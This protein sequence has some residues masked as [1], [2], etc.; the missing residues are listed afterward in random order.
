MD[1]PN[2]GWLIVLIAVFLVVFLGSGL[3][4]GMMGWGA[5]GRG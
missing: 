5:W 3:G 4:W 2:R 1:G